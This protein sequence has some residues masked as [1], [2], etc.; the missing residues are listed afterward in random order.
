MGRRL[1]RWCVI[2]GRKVSALRACMIDHGIQVRN[3]M[4]AGSF[5]ALPPTSCPI[6]AYEDE[7]VDFNAG[8]SHP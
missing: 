6:A 2:S 3:S 7:I 4:P 5:V 8:S 1:K